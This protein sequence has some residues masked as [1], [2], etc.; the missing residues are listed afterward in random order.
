MTSP[1][2]STSGSMAS[3]LAVPSPTTLSTKPCTPSASGAPPPLAGMPPPTLLSS[4]EGGALPSGCSRW[5]CTLRS[6]SAHMQTASGPGAQRA[7]PSDRPAR[8]RERCSPALVDLLLAW[9]EAPGDG[10]RLVA[11][12]HPGRGGDLHHALEPRGQLQRK[13]D[14]EQRV[15]ANACPS[16]TRTKSSV[17]VGASRPLT[18]HCQATGTRDGLRSVTVRCALAP[19]HVGRKYSVPVAPPAPPVLT[20]PLPAE[21]PPTPTSTSSRGRCPAPRSTTSVAA[22]ATLLSVSRAR[23]STGLVSTGE[24]RSATFARNQPAHSHTVMASPPCIARC[25]SRA[26]FSDPRPSAHAPG[27]GSWAAPRP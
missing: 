9:C 23:T 2:S 6:A 26:A 11:A 4:T 15:L 10:N 25:D 7:V 20:A 12:Q 3:A 14:G 5:Q 1:R 24:K 16:T 27:R 19:T 22:S 21:G 17:G 8:R 18:S 13:R